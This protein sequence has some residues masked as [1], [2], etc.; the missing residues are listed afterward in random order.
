MSF[1]DAL[2][3]EMRP[4]RRGPVAG[5]PRP[6]RHRVGAG[7]VLAQVSGRCGIE[8]H[9][10]TGPSSSGRWPDFSTQVTAANPGLIGV[11]DRPAGRRGL[12]ARRPVHQV[13]R[14]PGDADPVVRFWT[15]TGER[16]D[17]PG[18]PMPSPPPRCGTSVRPTPT[19]FPAAA[20]RREE[21]LG[22]EHAVI[23]TTGR[24]CIGEPGR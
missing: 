23:A 18:Q 13:A 6:D 16:R 19:T 12:P 17:D 22:F 10:T 7:G 15:A 8:R 5:G 11:V 21:A 1:T 9:G 4:A 14:G 2:A 24:C 20:L 3:E